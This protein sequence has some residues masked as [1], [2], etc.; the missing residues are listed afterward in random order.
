MRA[1]HNYGSARI[2]YSMTVCDLKRGS[3]AVVLKVELPEEMRARLRYLNVYKG[4]KI[5]LLKVS[6]FTKTSLEQAGSAK[7]VLD[8]ATAAGIR[9]WRI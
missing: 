6:H 8:R 5:A 2:F 9:I 4:A 7:V 1:E 3:G